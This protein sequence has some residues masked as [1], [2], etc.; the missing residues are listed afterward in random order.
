MALAPSQGL[1]LKG[2][3][4]F[5]SV[6]GGG[7]LLIGLKLR[8][9]TLLPDSLSQRWWLCN[10]GRPHKCWDYELEPSQTELPPFL[11]KPLHVS[12]CLERGTTPTQALGWWALPA[13]WGMNRD[14]G[15]R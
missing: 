6:V 4:L 7:Y 15:R 3:F 1:C 10:P 8:E 9:V 14:A 2:I 5:S 11:L 12:P 13:P